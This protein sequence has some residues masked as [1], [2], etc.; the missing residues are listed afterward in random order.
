MIRSKLYF[1]ILRRLSVQW[2]NQGQQ[3]TTID[4]TS[5]EDFQTWVYILR[6]LKSK[7]KMIVQELNNI[8]ATDQI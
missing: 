5:T 1:I 2:M 7:N 8:I 4:P 6:K 3:F